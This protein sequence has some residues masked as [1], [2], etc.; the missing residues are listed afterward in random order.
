MKNKIYGWFFVLVWMIIIF[1]LSHQPGTTSSGLSDEI[2][3]TIVSVLK[4][5][6]PVNDLNLNFLK[7]LIR[8]LAHLSA[9]TVLGYLVINALKRHMTV[10]IKSIGMAFLICLLYAI[11]DEVHQLFVPDRSGE[12]KDV[13]IDSVGAIFGISIYILQLRYTRKN[14]QLN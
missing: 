13:M 10:N 14:D 9:Y 1:Y 12:V 7:L 4:T 6:I 8:K 3:L 11:S 2:T 5:F